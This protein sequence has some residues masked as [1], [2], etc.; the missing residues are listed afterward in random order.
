MPKI[1]LS[2]LAE[3]TD[4]YS[5]SGDSYEL[6]ITIENGEKYIEVA[7]KS[8]VNKDRIEELKALII[9]DKVYFQN[10]I[11]KYISTLDDMDAIMVDQYLKRLR[12]H[13]QELNLWEGKVHE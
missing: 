13:V 7:E 12:Y 11:N 3:L 4:N 9:E 6:K 5:Y 8:E 10:S 2:Q 1:K